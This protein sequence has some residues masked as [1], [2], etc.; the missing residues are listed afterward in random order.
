MTAYAIYN[1]TKKRF[2]LDGN[3]E[4]GGV[5]QS[6]N[7]DEAEREAEKL[8]KHCRNQPYSKD[9]VFVVVSIQFN[10]PNA[11]IG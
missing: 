5:F 2:V 11:H 1:A 8:R 6:M 10:L 7:S 9:D 3:S 4:H